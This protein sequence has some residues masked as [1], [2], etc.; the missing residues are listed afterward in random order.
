MDYEIRKVRDSD[1][2]EIVGIANYFIDNSFANYME[3]HVDGKF[4]D[5][6][7]MLCRDGIFYVIE[8]P[9]GRLA[10]YGMLRHHMYPGLFKPAADT[11]YFI[12]PD[13]TNIGL[14]T[15]LLAL[16]EEDSIKSGIVT[17]L[18]NISSLNAQSLAFHRR[19]GFSE[20]GRFERIGRKFSCDFDIVWMQKFIGNK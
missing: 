17:L 8:S 15:R 13:Y 19:N 7:K 4:F 5:V 11:S 3:T 9:Q 18:A 20:C 14:G 6:A 10:G 16:L 12:L 2:D 1:A